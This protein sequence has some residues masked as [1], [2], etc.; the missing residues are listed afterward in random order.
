MNFEYRVPTSV[1]TGAGQEV[2]T[3]R[4]SVLVSRVARGIGDVL[5]ALV[6]VAC[7]AAAVLVSWEAAFRLAAVAAV[8]LISRL[9]K[10]PA[11]VDSAIC[12]TLPLATAASLFEWYR[13]VAWLDVVMHGVTSGAM[14]VAAFYV[15]C[16]T[17]LL[18]RQHQFNDTSSV[19]VV[20]MIGIT[21]GVL[22]EF[23]EWFVEVILHLRIG[24]GYD[25]TILDLA[26]D[27]VGTVAAGLALVA[28]RRRAVAK[29]EAQAQ[30]R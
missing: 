5:R 8:L 12:V 15:L 24:V 23:Y 3:R 27:T 26:M 11:V 7:P 16:R 14:A 20:T 6:I 9:L 1:S 17:P 28:I 21:L 22:W 30:N 29:D 2:A 4:R 10:L 25:D 18:P 13:D 19:L